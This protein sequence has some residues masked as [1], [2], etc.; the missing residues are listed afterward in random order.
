MNH[1]GYFG[2]Y[3]YLPLDIG[4]ARSLVQ[5]ENRELKAVGDKIR[6]SAN[7]HVSHGKA[8]DAL[9]HIF[10]Q[11]GICGLYSGLCSSM[12]GTASINFTFVY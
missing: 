3:I 10:R 7:E 6:E 12:F 1:R 9:L 5:I 4:K 8:L 11:D 2:Q